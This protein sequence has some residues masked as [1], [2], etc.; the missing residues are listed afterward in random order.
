MLQVNERIHLK[1]SLK[2]RVVYMYNVYIYILL[3]GVI[4]VIRKQIYLSEEMNQRLQQIS[5]DRG[6]PQ[7]EIIREGLEK[8]ITINEDKEQLWDQLYQDMK[9]SKIKNINWDRDELYQS[10]SGEGNNE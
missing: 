8:Y 2:K 4:D 1:I 7:S 3:N 6:V 9:G 10:R 5:K